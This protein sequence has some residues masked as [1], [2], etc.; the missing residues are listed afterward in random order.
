MIF[1]GSLSFSGDASLDFDISS[2]LAGEMLQVFWYDCRGDIDGLN[3]LMRVSTNGGSSFDS[4][5]NYS[6][7][8]ANWEAT[9]GAGNSSL[10][11][12]SLPMGSLLSGNR[13]GHDAGEGIS[14]HATL[15]AP[16]SALTSHWV[17]QASYISDSTAAMGL[18]GFSGRYNTASAITDVQVLAGGATADLTSGEVHFYRVK[19]A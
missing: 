10:A 5:T 2:M 12:T 18:S 14:G 17:G 8:N 15:F 16:R 3:L 13:A 6:Y 1:L 11:T 19:I 7:Q 9:I 4:G